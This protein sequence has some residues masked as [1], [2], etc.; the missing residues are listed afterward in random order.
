M[1]EENKEPV[2]SSDL[3]NNFIQIDQQG[4]NL[5]KES[6]Q[7]NYYS[8]WRSESSYSKKNYESDINAHLYGRL[9]GD[10][11]KIIPWL[12]NA[13]SLRG[14]N[15]LEIG[16]GTG[17]SVVALSEQGA[18]VIGIDIDDGALQVARD[19]SKA[20][21]LNIDI[22][23]MNA[24]NILSHFE[25]VQFDFIVFFACLEH[26]T[27][28]ERITS[29]KDA[30]K[31]LP[32]NSFLV[33]VETPNRLWYFDDHTS[34][35]PFFHW[36]PDELA[37]EYSKFSTRENYRELYTEYNETLKDHFLRRG[38]GMSFHEIDISIGPTAGLD[39]VSSLSIFDAPPK[40]LEFNRHY[41]SMIMAIYPNIHNGFFDKTLYLILRKK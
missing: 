25:G 12:N 32:V 34:M 11:N 40:I 14:K 28:E 1:I 39:V 6:L 2:K 29:L 26:M 7:A 9:I 15:I 18:K 23:N 5:I 41:K 3:S 20:Y 10:R 27:I 19:R 22:R 16:C 35:L 17:S 13:S 8:G 38:R 24:R 31:M 21:G 30:W 4:F 33:I 37:F 36:L